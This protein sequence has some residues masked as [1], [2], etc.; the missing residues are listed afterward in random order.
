MRRKTK[1]GLTNVPIF[2]FK[3]IEHQGYR[4][5]GLKVRNAVDEW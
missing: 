2:L 1:P 4:W 5:L 3:K